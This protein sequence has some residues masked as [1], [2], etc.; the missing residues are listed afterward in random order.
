MNKTI[1]CDIDGTLLKHHGGLYPI[2]QEKPELLPNV[3]EAIVSWKNKDYKIIL[4]TGRPESMR[5][6]TIDQLNTTGIFYDMLIMGLP[7]GERI[8]I[9]DCKPDRTSTAKAINVPRNSGFTAEHFIL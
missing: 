4:T 6:L 1:F 9:N 8:V 3:I 7:R 5:K 2:T